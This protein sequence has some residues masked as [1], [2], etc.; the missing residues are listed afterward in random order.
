MA[1]EVATKIT[2]NDV[3][4]NIADLSEN[5]TNQLKGM[6]I[7]R[8]EMKRLTVQLALVETAS[9]AYGTALSA[10]LPKPAAED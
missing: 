10:D 9:N 3:D 1:E 8:A 7:A 6:Q 5:A 2:I 4:Y